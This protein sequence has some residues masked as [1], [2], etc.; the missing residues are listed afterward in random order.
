MIICPKCYS[1]L[2]R[3]N[4]DLICK[5]CNYKA[6]QKNS[7]IF[8]SHENN[9]NFH[10]YN[11]AGLDNLF[12]AEGKNFWFI[13]RKLFIRNLF[14]KYVSKDAKI[15]EVGSGTGDVAG[16]LLSQG[17]D[18]SVG[19]IHPKGLEYA[20]NYGIKELY[21]FDM[22]NA[23]FMDHFDAVGLF[24]VLEHIE[25]DTL[26]IKNVYQMLKREGRVIITVPAHQWLWNR[27]DAIALHKRRYDLKRLKKLFIEN[28]FEILEA[29]H[30]FVLILPL[31][32]L[33]TIIN[34]D[35][36][37]SPK[38]SEIDKEIS[39]KPIVNRILDYVTRLE[40]IVLKNISLPFGGSIA[41]VARKK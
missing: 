8:F 2:R 14:N 37:S 5:K 39:I 40:I 36:G 30:F 34:R 35:D 25:D 38:Q 20:K 11:P 41:V 22:R 7:I 32:F 19:D 10:D 33:R 9:N 28:G 1:K 31:L 24:D 16:M 23:P 26:A 6:I 29:R 13:N 12:K 17:Y 4:S 21:Q 18:V 15:I 27:D 3:I